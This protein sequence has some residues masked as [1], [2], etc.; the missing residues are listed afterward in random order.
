[1]QLISLTPTQRDK[2]MKARKKPS[3]HKCT[4]TTCCQH[5][6]S[7]I[8]KEH[9]AIN[10]VLGV[11]HEKGRRRFVGLLALQWGRGSLSYLS[12][13][14]DLSRPTIR[15]GRAEVQQGERATDRVRVRRAGAGRPLTEKNNRGC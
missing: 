6:G 14:T 9:R 5:P 10:R 12:Q 11:L 4:C 13:I 8:A 2:L 15:R 7:A 3:I 1:L